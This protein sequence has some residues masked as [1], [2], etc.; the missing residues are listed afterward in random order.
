MAKRKMNLNAALGTSFRMMLPGEEFQS[1][2][3]MVTMTGLPGMNMAGVDAPYSNNATNFPS[4]RIEYDPLNLTFLIDEDYAN[5]DAIRL[6]MH[7]ICNTEPVVKE[8]KDITLHLTNSNKN[9]IIGVKFYGAYPTMLA[10]VPLE[11]GTSDAIPPTCSMTF[12]YQYYDFVR[13]KK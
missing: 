8:M 2:N 3:Y 6:W 4:N 12:R 13:T 9:S 1:L 11:S 10:E 7:R 5:F